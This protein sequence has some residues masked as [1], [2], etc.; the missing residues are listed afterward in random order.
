MFPG[1]NSLTECRLSLSFSSLQ[2]EINSLVQKLSAVYNNERTQ[3]SH[4][5]GDN[6]RYEN[7]PPVPVLDFKYTDADLNDRQDQIDC[8]SDDD[9]HARNRAVSTPV[10]IEAG[11]FECN[12]PDDRRKN[13]RPEYLNDEVRRLFHRNVL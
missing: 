4:H 13:E 3:K 9:G 11:I 6:Q 7:D 8:A 1:Q 2:P 12:V 5:S 10:K